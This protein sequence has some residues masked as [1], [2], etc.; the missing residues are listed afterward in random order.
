M[1]EKEAKK[2]KVVRSILNTASKPDTRTSLL[3]AGWPQILVDEYLEKIAKKVKRLERLPTSALIMLNNVS[4][5]FG[6]H[7]VLENVNLEIVPGEI[8]GIIGL[9]GT[10]KTTLLNMIVGF[11]EPDSGEIAVKLSDGSVTTIFQSPELVK[12]LYGFSTQNTS[13]YNK[14]TVRENLQHFGSLYGINPVL[15]NARINDLL[16]LV[17][18]SDSADVIAQHLSGGMQ[19]RLDIACAMIHE[20]KVLILDEPTADLDPL[21]RKQMW[22][23]IEKINERGTTI[24]VAS[25]FVSEIEDGCDRVAVLSNRTVSKVGAIDEVIAAYSKNYAI[26]IETK[27]KKY[28]SLIKGISRLKSIKYQVQGNSMTLSTANP[29]QALSWLSEYIDASKD[30]IVKLNMSKPSLGEVFESMVKK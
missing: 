25:H 3:S 11:L 12:T 6:E 16:E 30:Q 1:K 5:K 23:L 28:D 20:P 24:I 9:S 19:K 7:V 2:T 10:G 21:L 15:L 8:F 14:L 22:N 27:T 4:K 17:G 18:L 29:R 13:F 26:Q